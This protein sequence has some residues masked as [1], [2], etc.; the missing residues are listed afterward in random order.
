MGSL[1]DFIKVSELLTG[2]DRLDPGVGDDYRRRIE[3]APGLALDDLVTVFHQSIGTPKPLEK[4]TSHFTGDPQG[5]KLRRT[6]QQVVR[7]WYLSE[8]VDGNGA[9][10]SAN[11]FLDSALYRAIEAHAPSFSDQPHGYWSKAPGGKD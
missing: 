7:V 2:L 8:Y 11:H 4:L 6:A 1:Q 5:Q 9:L 3:A 10:T